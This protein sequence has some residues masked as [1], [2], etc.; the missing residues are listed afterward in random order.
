MIKIAIVGYEFAIF[1][2]YRHNNTLCLA[3]VS[4]VKHASATSAFGIK[5][6]IR[7]PYCLLRCR[8]KNDECALIV[9]EP[10][11]YGFVNLMKQGIR[12][13]FALSALQCKKDARLM[14]HACVGNEYRVWTCY[15]RRW[16]NDRPSRNMILARCFYNQCREC[17]IFFFTSCLIRKIHALAW[18]PSMFSRITY[19]SCNI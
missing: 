14:Q 3:W 10:A 12:A 1:F 4:C 16:S 2:C 11:F 6:E 7:L 19:L 5:D 8:F 17:V 9:T 15:D 18:I 13:A